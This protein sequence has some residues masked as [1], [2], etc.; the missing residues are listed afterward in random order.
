MIIDKM[1]KDY[2]ELTKCQDILVKREILVKRK[3]KLH[4]KI[5]NLDKQLR[6][7]SSELSLDNYYYHIGKFYRKENQKLMV[8]RVKYENGNVILQCLNHL[9]V[10]L[11]YWIINTLNFVEITREE[12]CDTDN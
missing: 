9:G 4:T 11:D 8:T 1:N 7:Y 5:I 2:V 10:K 6:K 3:D 12:Y